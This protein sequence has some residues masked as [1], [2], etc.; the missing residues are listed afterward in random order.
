M[1]FRELDCE[2][3]PIEVNDENIAF[4]KE[5][6]LGKWAERYNEREEENRK[7]VGSIWHRSAPTDLSD[8]CKFS[9]LFSSVVFGGEIAGN[10]DHVF[11]LV[12]DEVLDLNEDAADVTALDDPHGEDDD[13]IY[14]GDFKESISS[15]IPRVRQWL[16]DFA[17]ELALRAGPKP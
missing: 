16:A 4:A 10:Y 5:F 8:S 12:D 9:A 6:L 15:C 3:F 13:F 17:A 14:S 7:L 1:R 2:P 11:T